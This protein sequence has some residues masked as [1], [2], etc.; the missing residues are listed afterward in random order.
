MSE[1]MYQKVIVTHF[2]ETIRETLKVVETPFRDP[3]PNELLVHNYYAGVN[4]N[5]LPHVM[6]RLPNFSRPP[7]DFGLEAIGKVVAVGSH[8]T[9]HQVGD[10]VVTLMIGNGYREYSL[11]DHKL[12]WKVNSISPQ[13]MALLVSGARASIALR[14]AARLKRGGLT[15]LVTAAISGSGHYAV[16]LAKMMGNH[17]IGTCRSEDEANLLAQ[18]GC[19]RIINRENEDLDTVLGQEYPDGIQVVYDSFGGRIF[20]ICLD[21]LAPRGRII[22]AETLAEH[23]HHEESVH[24]LPIYDKLIWKAATIHGFNLLEY[25]QFILP[26]TIYLIDL[27]ETGQIRS[28][29][30]PVSFVGLGSV[31]DAL[32]HIQRWQN[33]GK[34]VI[35]LHQEA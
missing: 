12:A 32:E 26:H 6:G 33:R 17:V 10:A 31:A 2:S 35:K 18:L 13:V 16:Q 28:L 25:A 8:V 27:Y 4:F 24:R 9:E 19:D 34:V 14:V 21:H 1:K 22:V 11:I 5:D 29:I 23:T 20:D 15:V 3:G 30:D 7:F